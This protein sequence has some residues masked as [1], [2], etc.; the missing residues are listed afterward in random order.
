MEKRTVSFVKKYTIINIW[1]EKVFLKAHTVS[2]N[3]KI[4]K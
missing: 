2:H 1:M 3:L 4:W